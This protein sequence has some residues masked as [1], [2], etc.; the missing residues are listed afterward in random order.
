MLTSLR[1]RPAASDDGWLAS[2]S[3]VEARN[4]APAPGPLDKWCLSRLSRALRGSPVRFQLWDGATSALAGETPIATVVIEDRRTLV[5]LLTQP[6]IEF[7]EAYTSGR[8]T[9]QGDLVACLEGVN[10]ALSGRRYQRGGRYARPVSRADSR[11]NVRHYDLGNDFYRLWLDADL[12]YTCAYYDRPDATLEDAQ[13]AKLEYVCRKLRLRPGERVVEAGCGWGALALHMARHYGVTVRAYNIS[14]EQLEFAKARAAREGLDHLVTFVGD[15]YRSIEERCD[16]F[17]SIGMLEH[18][19]AAQYPTLGDV[20]DRVLDPDRGRGLLHFIGRNV[21]LEF[22]PWITRHIFPGRICADAR[23]G[24][25]PDPAAAE[26]LRRGRREPAPALRS[27]APGL[28]DTLRRTRSHHRR[29]VR[30]VVRPDVAT[31]PGVGPVLLPSGDLQLFQVTFGRAAD[32]SQPW[33]R[34]DLYAARASGGGPPS[35]RRRFGELGRSL[36]G[37]QAP[38]ASQKSP[39]EESESASAAARASGWGPASE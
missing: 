38:R 24:D 30:R 7:G 32:N 11:R 2:E 18:V 3:A 20:V 14:A 31:L 10:R 6:A 12:V 22:N 34:D 19:G 1:R 28:A 37:G 36:G 5:G 17:V 27:H 35:R 33:T 16:A 8:L 39:R 9:V 13:H 21:P 25:G 4:Q 23:R 26:P 15:D 29:D